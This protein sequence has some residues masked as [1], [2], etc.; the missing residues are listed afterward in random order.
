MSFDR[1]RAEA[2]ALG[3]P[4]VHVRRLER[5]WLRGLPLDAF[6]DRLG[7]PFGR[8]LRAALPDFERRLDAVV[9]VAS[10]HSASDGS[11]RL[12]LRLVDGAL[13]ETVLLPGQA[14]CVSTQLGCAVGCPFCKTGDDGL[15]RQLSSDELLAQ[16]VLA[17]R[18]RPLRRVLFLG[19]GE[20]A[21]NLEALRR[22]LAFLGGEGDLPHKHLVVSTVGDRRLFAALGADR[23][24][25][26][27]A[28]SL[29]SV[30]EERRAML[31]PRAPRIPVP[32]LVALAQDHAERT[33]W[34]VQ[35]EWTLLDRVNDSLAEAD[36]L[37]DLLRG[38]R[39]MVNYIPWNRV[40]GK[41][42]RRPPR[43][44]CEALVARL[45]AR[46]VIATLRDSAGQDEDAG[47][48]QLRARLA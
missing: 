28:I 33:T 27:L 6:A 40:D 30:D 42:F 14:V 19:M 39:A 21:H 1:I 26:A 10:E 17:R 24:K 16:V 36:R 34:P 46:G 11:T 20:P 12:V 3:A 48:G 45:R 38:R 44:R 41:P 32:E 22:A 15:L 8:R 5:A 7:Q 29:H 2:G 13:C 18:R 9:E 23:V 4:E 43:P 47:C 37:A 31:V 35:Y 25:P